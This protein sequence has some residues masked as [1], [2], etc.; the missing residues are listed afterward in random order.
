MLGEADKTPSTVCMCAV[1]YV[2][3]DEVDLTPSPPCLQAVSHSG[4]VDTD[5]TASQIL[6]IMNRNKMG[7]EVTFLPLN[8]LHPPPPHHPTSQVCIHTHILLPAL[9]AVLTSDSFNRCKLVFL[10]HLTLSSSSLKCNAQL[11]GC[12]KGDVPPRA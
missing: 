8:K 7:G 11:L 10:L 4:H 12:G 9:H 1:L 5:C 3:W 6:S 2:V